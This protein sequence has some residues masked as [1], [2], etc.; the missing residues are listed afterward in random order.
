MKSELLVKLQG[1]DLIWGH[2]YRKLVM[3]KIQNTMKVTTIDKDSREI[4]INHNEST[5]LW[6]DQ[7]KPKWQRFYLDEEEVLFQ[8][9]NSGG[10]INSKLC[11]PRKL[12]RD[13]NKST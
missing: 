7:Y 9:M 8:E 12:A 11:I 5:S 13:L 3:T 4:L 2:L 1:E 6:I 10:S